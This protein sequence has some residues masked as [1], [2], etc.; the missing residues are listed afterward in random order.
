MSNGLTLWRY[1]RVARVTLNHVWF[2]TVRIRGEAEI[3]NEERV[4]RRAR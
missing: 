4:A 3:D 2:I 1:W